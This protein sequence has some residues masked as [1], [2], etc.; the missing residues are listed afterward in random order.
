MNSISHIKISPSDDGHHTT[1]HTV[2]KKKLL[3]VVAFSSLS[4]E[5]D[6]KGQCEIFTPPVRLHSQHIA[7]KDVQN[8]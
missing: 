6:F 1:N 4:T 7:Y 5:A 8:C 2:N 3:V